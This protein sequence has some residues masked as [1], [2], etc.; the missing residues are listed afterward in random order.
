M[1]L[2]DFDPRN[3]KPRWIAYFDLLGTSDR[4]SG[5]DLFSAFS[6]YERAIVDLQKHEFFSD[7][8]IGV[9][10]FSDSFLIYSTNS[11]LSEFWIIDHVARWFLVELLHAGLPATGAISY[12]ELYADR[13]NSIFFGVGLIDAVKCCEI[14][15][16]IGLV[17]SE[18]ASKALTEN[19]VVIEQLLDYSVSEVPRR[20][21]NREVEITDCPLFLPC[22]IFGCDG[23]IRGQ[24]SAIDALKRL[25]DKVENGCPSLSQR[26]IQRILGSSSI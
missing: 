5:Q 14:Q 23:M 22:F 21:S 24:Q 15:D 6:V 25:R 4:V 20:T 26:Q 13:G 1:R 17:I 19:K 3:S 10:W 16:W 11:D 9:S 7:S 8:S 2:L 18:S 12:G